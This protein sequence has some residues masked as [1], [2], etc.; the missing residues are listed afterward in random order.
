MKLSRDN[1]HLLQD[2]TPR[3]QVKLS[4]VHDDHVLFHQSGEIVRVSI[5]HM[6]EILEAHQ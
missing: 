3:L 5:A 6:R 4:R 1:W 2:G